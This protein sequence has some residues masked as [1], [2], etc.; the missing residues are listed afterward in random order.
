MTDTLR[1]FVLSYTLYEYAG[2]RAG[3]E[4]A[5]PLSSGTGPV[6]R[7]ARGGVDCGSNSSQEEG[8]WAASCFCHGV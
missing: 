4:D 3:V 7:A 1:D 2:P 6:G 5:V 8:P